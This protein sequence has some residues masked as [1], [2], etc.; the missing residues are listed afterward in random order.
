ML[1][2]LILVAV[3]LYEDEGGTAG[4]LA[5]ANEIYTFFT[6]SITEPDTEKQ[7]CKVNTST[8]S[9]KERLFLSRWFSSLFYGNPHQSIRGD[10]YSCMS[11]PEAQIL[12]LPKRASIHFFQLTRVRRVKKHRTRDP[13]YYDVITHTGSTKATH[14]LLTTYSLLTR[15]LLTTCSLL[16]ASK[17]F[18]VYVRRTVKLFPWEKYCHACMSSQSPGLIF[19]PQEFEFSQHYSF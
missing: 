8:S 10:M 6:R 9:R 11:T 1:C 16:Q 17:E 7:F 18:Q 3:N 15:Y 4:W 2:C 12:K 14:Y 5:T 19:V 13:R